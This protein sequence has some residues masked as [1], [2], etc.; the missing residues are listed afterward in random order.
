[1]SPAA[2]IRDSHSAG[3]RPPAPG[4]RMDRALVMLLAAATGLAVASNYYVQP[5]LPVLQAH[6]RLHGSVA[7]LVVTAGQVGYAIGLIFVLP[8]GDLFE[9]RRLIVVL[10]VGTALALVGFALSTSA[11]QVMTAAAFVGVLSV[12]AQLLVPFAASLAAD[13]ERGKV[14]G[15]VM[16][17]L[18][19]GIL[20]ARTVAGYLAELGGWP[21]VY[22]VAAGL[23]L[24]SAVAL[25]FRLPRF[26]SEAGLT[27]P[28][29]IASTWTLVWHEPVLRLRMLYGAVS[30]G[31]F[32]VLWTSIAFL[33]AGAPYHY[34]TGTIGLFGLVGAAGALAANAAGRLA[35]AGHVRFTTGTAAILLCVS[36]WPVALGRHSLLAL[37][38]GVVVL[39][40][41]VQ[42]LHISNQSQIYQLRPE[43]RARLTS[44]YMTAYFVGGAAG[45]ALSTAAYVHSGWTAVCVV[46]AAFG[47]LAIVL[48]AATLLFARRSPAASSVAAA[49]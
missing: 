9:R 3:A 19:L 30:F 25:R 26:H 46:G 49:A 7:G 40:L 24:A 35:D 21:T 28:R 8:L 4:A 45:S 42:G 13:D 38:I 39:D 33:L 32:N 1:M 31:G 47:A 11:A 10:S 43:A 17:G 2:D 18:L 44:A 14:V 20:V 12:V 34:S 22:W 37:V 6:L 5:L 41:A 48:W 16:G 36:W 29:L 27:Y 15:T 23:M